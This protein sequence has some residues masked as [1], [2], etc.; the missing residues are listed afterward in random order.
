MKK[1]AIVI[2]LI[3]AL[4]VSYGQ[5]LQSDNVKR[6]V[7]SEDS[8][9]VVANKILQA[10]TVEERKKSDSLFTKM[11]V[12]CLKTSYSYFYQFSSLYNISILY[13]PDSSFRIFTWQL[14]IDDNHYI[15]HG[16]IQ[17]NTPDGA[18]KLIP[19]FDKSNS[20]NEP[21]D[22]ICSNS[23]WIGA[24]YYKIVQKQYNG[25][26]YYTLLGYNEFGLASNKKI[27]DVLYFENNNAI[28]GG[29]F[30]SITNDE[31]PK[32]NY[33][34]LVIEYKKNAAPRLNYDEDM[35]MIIKEH[36]IS[37]NNQPELKYT[38]I[39]DGDY[40]GFYW[41]EGKWIYVNK[42]FDSKIPK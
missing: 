21:E 19:L 8:M 42:V 34:R 35:G 11:L 32:I 38:L 37:E 28:F 31:F 25:K 12:R 1:T 33:Y 2:S 24:I 3:L 10:I 36:L 4:Q 5:V 20:I 15:H 17:M 23:S 39:G 26:N 6:I 29:H 14:M 9:K 18:L 22:T 7:K 13:P 16:A 41:K 30:F 27:I 40:E